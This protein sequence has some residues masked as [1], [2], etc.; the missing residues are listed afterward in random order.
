MFPSLTAPPESP[1]RHIRHGFTLV[2]L[3]TAIAIISILCA[4]SIPLASKLRE[5]T[6]ASQ[7]ASN[8]RQL[9]QGTLLFASENGGTFPPGY[10]WDREIAPYLSISLASQP[11]ETP[12]SLI[13]I[14]PVDSRGR[15]SRPRSYVASAQNVSNATLAGCGIFSRNASTSSLRLSQLVVPARTILLAEY[16]TGGWSASTQFASA[17]ATVDGWMGLAAA[18]K[19]ENGKYYHGSSGQNYAFADGHVECLTPDK[20]VDSGNFTTGGRWRAYQP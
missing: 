19:L 18:P 20:V 8:L 7:C 1:S 17:Y 4:L 15:A 9:A 3:L 11:S 14:C 13:F 5:S 16:F 12:L 10:I 6:R 2:E